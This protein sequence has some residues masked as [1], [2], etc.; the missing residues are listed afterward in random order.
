MGNIFRHTGINIGGLNP[1]SWIY[2][3]DVAIF[4]GS[5]SSLYCLVVPKPGKSWNALYGTPETIQLESEQ[6]DT[7]GGMKYLYKLKMLVP[8]DRITVE[9]ELFRMTGRQLIIK[10]TDKNG[11]I[12]ILGT[13]ESPMK[14]TNKLLKPAALETYNGYELLFTGEFSKPA[15]FVWDPNS[16]IPEDQ[17]LD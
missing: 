8:K 5:D 3:E 14:L 1:V 6:Q 9:D 4:S 17:N 10:L 16:G 12:R 13:M 2:R 11:T 7:P 15:G